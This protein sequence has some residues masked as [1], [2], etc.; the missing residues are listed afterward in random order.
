MQRITYAS[1][2]LI[3]LAAAYVFNFTRLALCLILIHYAVECVFH[4]ARLLSFAEKSQVAQVAFTIYNGAFVVVRLGSIILSVLTFWYGL[5]LVDS[6][7]IDLQ[8]GNFNTPALRINCLLSACLI[9]AWMMWNYINFHL[10][11]IR[12]HSQA[13]KKKSGA[14]K[15]K[16]AAKLKDEVKKHS[17][18]DVSEL[19]E[20]D[21]NTKKELRAR[22]K[23]KK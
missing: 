19:P 20:V 12:E 21:Q 3:F 16:K 9:Q 14:K 15:E 5:R 7:H 13:L 11:R 23:G 4:V 2:Y 1:L 17:E 6:D 8:T 10:K 18:E 22:N